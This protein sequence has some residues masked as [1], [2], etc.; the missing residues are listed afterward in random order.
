MN[1]LYDA[2]KKSIHDY[3]HMDKLPERRKRRIKEIYGQF[4]YDYDVV[5]TLFTEEEETKEKKNAKK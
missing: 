4:T 2:L 5:D 3:V 1:D